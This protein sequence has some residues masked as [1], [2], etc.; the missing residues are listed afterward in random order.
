[1]PARVAGLATTLHLFASFASQH[2]LAIGGPGLAQSTPTKRHDALDKKVQWVRS[3]ALA[4]ATDPGGQIGDDAASFCT[5]CEPVHTHN[6]C[7][8]G[9]CACTEHADKASRRA[10][11]GA[12][13]A[14]SRPRGCHRSRRPQW[15]RRC[16]FLHLLRASAHS[17]K[18]PLW[19]CRGGELAVAGSTPTMTTIVQWRRRRLGFWRRLRVSSATRRPRGVGTQ[20]TVVSRAGVLVCCRVSA[21]LGDRTPD[22]FKVRAS[23]VKST[24]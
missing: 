13:G 12:Y 5:F 2:T 21:G 23:Q 20:K 4:A 22:T 14:L 18:V 7:H 1:M 9:P 10:G 19:S 3:R 17:Q 6:R 15:R 11:K 24:D 16:I 8:Y